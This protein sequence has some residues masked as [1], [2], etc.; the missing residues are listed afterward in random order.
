M[1]YNDKTLSD[2]IPGDADLERGFASIPD[3]PQNR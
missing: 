3:V 2:Q 1:A